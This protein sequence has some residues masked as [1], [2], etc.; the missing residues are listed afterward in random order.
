VRELVDRITDGKIAQGQL[1]DAPL[2]LRDLRIVK[3]QLTATLAGIYHHRIDY[4]AAAVNP[5]LADAPGSVGE[6]AS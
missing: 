1:D 2:T 5:A 4:P 6:R 3:E